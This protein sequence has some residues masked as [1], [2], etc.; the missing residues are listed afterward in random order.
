MERAFASQRAVAC[1]SSQ[2]NGKGRDGQKI[3]RLSKLGG[4]IMIILTRF[5]NKWINHMVS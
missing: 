4:K 1:V 2:A 5:P 3:N